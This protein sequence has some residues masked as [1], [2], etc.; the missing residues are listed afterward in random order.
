[1]KEIK[2]KTNSKTR[3]VSLRRPI[4]NLG[5]NK[6]EAMEDY[7]EE[8]IHVGDTVGPYTFDD[9]VVFVI[10]DDDGKFV[11]NFKY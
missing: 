2:V 5:G 4:D 7:P 1:M 8:N 11:R 9:E 6:Y 10:H 3:G